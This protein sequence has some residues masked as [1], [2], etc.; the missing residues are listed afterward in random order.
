MQPEDNIKDT[1]LQRQNT[2]AMMVN[3]PHYIERNKNNQYER[4]YLP[5]V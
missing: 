1:P 4:T 2:L 3:N 5:Q